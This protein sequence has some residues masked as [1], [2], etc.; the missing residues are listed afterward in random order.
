MLHVECQGCH[1]SAYVDCTCP[2]G[3]TDTTGAHRDA[4]PMTD[5]GAT[6]VCPPGT[7]CCKEAHSHDQNANSCPALASGELHPEAPCPVP[8][9]ADFSPDHVDCTGGHCGFGVPDCTVCR[10]VTITVMPGSTVISAV[11]G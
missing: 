11:G 8:A 5:L 6:V 7:N 9:H 10:P 1:T 4:C 3:H 2:Q